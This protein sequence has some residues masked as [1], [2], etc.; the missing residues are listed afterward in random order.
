MKAWL[1]CA[2]LVV[3][4]CNALP[5]LRRGSCGNGV[6][7]EHEDC[8][9][10]AHATGRCSAPGTPLEC[11]FVCDPDA[12]RSAPT[13]PEGYG[14]SSEGVCRRATGEYVPGA[15]VSKDDPAAL[16]SGDFDGNGRADILSLGP[17]NRLG[18]RSMRLYYVDQQGA[19]LARWTTS[20]SLGAPSVLDLSNDG[21][22]D[23]LFA[24][25]GIGVLLGQPDRTLL[26]QTFP[27]L[28]FPSAGARVAMVYD[29]P[30]QNTMPL[31]ALASIDGESGL[32]RVEPSG[33]ELTRITELRQARDDILGVV[34][35]DFLRSDAYP[36]LEIAIVYSD[37]SELSVYSVCEPGRDDTEPVWRAQALELRAE[38]PRAPRPDDAPPLAADLDRDGAVDLVVAARGELYWLRAPDGVLLEPAPI[39]LGAGARS[40][41]EMPL[42]VGDLNA[43]GSA[44]FVFT[45]AIVI[46]GQPEEQTIRL[47]DEPWTHA[48]IAD[49]NANG[50]LDV[51]ASR[52]QGQFALDFYNGDGTGQFTHFSVETAGV[53]KHLAVGDLDGDY[54]N[55]VSLVLKSQ[56]SGEE[57]LAV[58]F[59]E[60]NRPPQTPVNVARL[61]PVAQLESFVLGPQGHLALMYATPSAEDGS[62]LV[63]FAGSG[64]RLPIA[65]YSLLRIS[66]GAF[67][68]GAP[69]VVAP[70]DF[71]GNAVPD[72][73]ALALSEAPGAPTTTLWGVRDLPSATHEPRVLRGADTSRLLPVGADWSRPQLTARLDAGNLDQDPRDELVLLSRTADGA[74]TLHVGE[75]DGELTTSS[76]LATEAFDRGCHGDD[77]VELLDVD[78]D[79]RPDLVWLVEPTRRGELVALFNDGRGRFSAARLARLSASEHAVRAFTSLSHAEGGAAALVYLT[80]TGA[81]R[82]AL[83]FPF[84]EPPTQ[85]AALSGATAL[86]AGDFDGDTVVDL[87]VAD[88][89]AIHVLLARTID[90]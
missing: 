65:P 53:V 90:P 28:R 84:A 54:V 23:L 50:R 15:V 78:A 44:D 16:A 42:A 34:T 77:R 76:W 18:Q 14:C 12:P 27:S 82:V 49:L 13:C 8:D 72:V 63:L 47:L 83:P 21:R 40:A 6:V 33:V 31:V 7:E 69:V 24:A 29:R 39:R 5:E 70:G 86:T 48:I 71:D 60:P 62:Q 19:E 73:V 38:L 58:G 20:K 3:G 25:D 87:A 80:E 89:G 10:H 1:F 74:C 66:E 57:R 46:T 52:S 45:T 81:Y 68:E 59:G 37:S 56:G 2:V 55:D 85:V 36:C 30:V 17:P 88:A 75:V 79:G 35:A 4:G 32:F 26:P 51:I 22:D 9:L 67:D 41:P 11:R 64:D 43:D 61:S